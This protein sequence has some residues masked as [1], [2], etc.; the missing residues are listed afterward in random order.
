MCQFVSFETISIADS[1]L[2]D[3][4][5]PTAAQMFNPPFVYTMAISS[6]GEWIAAGLGDT[7]I[8]LLSPLNKKQ[9]KSQEIRLEN[10]HNSMVNCL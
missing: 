1:S 4:K 6:N 9:K 3:P 8:Q 5:E 2:I 7:T 10:G